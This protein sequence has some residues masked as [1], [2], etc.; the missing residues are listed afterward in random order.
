MISGKKH[1][2]KIQFTILKFYPPLAKPESSIFFRW[3]PWQNSQANNNCQPSY[4]ENTIIKRYNASLQL[5]NIFKTLNKHNLNLI[6]HFHNINQKTI[7]P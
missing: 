6:L 1:Q 3:I 4:F 2:S 7:I 5:L